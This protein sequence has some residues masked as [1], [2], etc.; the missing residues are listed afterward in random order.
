MPDL[1]SLSRALPGRVLSAEADLRSYSF[2]ASLGRALPGAVVLARSALEVRA[3]VDWC[4]RSGVP[5]VAR[6][7]G[8]NLSGGCVPLRGAVVVSTAAMNRILA[9]SPRDS[10]ALVEPGVVNLRLQRALEPEGLFFPPDPASHRVCTI[11]GNIGENA[12]GP[13]C[14][15]YG[16]TTHHV[17]ALEA[18]LPDGSAARF[19]ASDP[20]P[21]LLSLFVGSEGTLGVATRAS[22]NIQRDPPVRCALLAGFSSIEDAVGA[23]SAVIAAG[24][25]PRTLEAMDRLTVELIEAFVP[26]GYPRTEAVLLLELEDGEGPSSE[27]QAERV[28]ELLRGLGACELRRAEGPLERERLWEGRRSAYAA[29]A[30]RA[31]S[32]LV[33]DGVVPRGRLPEAARRIREIAASE[34]VTAS[35]LF[36]AGDGNIHPNMIFD[37]RDREATARVRRAGRRML[38]ACVE[39][40]GSISG[41][42]GIGTEKRAAMGSMF[43]EPALEV[44]SRIRRAFDPSLLSNP[45]K[46]LP[47][48]GERPPGGL[49]R[50][51][52]ALSAPAEA[53]RAAVRERA[54]EG[55]PFSVFGARSRVP[56]EV[57]SAEKAGAFST[58]GLSSIVRLD[59]ED[60]TVTVEAGIL[61]NDLLGL[62]EA[63][64][65]HAPLPPGKGT[66]GGLMAVKPPPPLRDALLGVRVVLADGSLA[67]FGG[68]T[69]KNVAGY[70][71][72][73][74]L[75]GSWGTLAVIL[76]AT[77]RLSAI[78]V[79]A[80]R[81]PAR[82]VPP[83]MGFWHK[84]LQEALDP[85]GLLN[86]WY[87]RLYG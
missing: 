36:H 12:G 80:G 47:L 61:V 43:D 6:G 58:R 18:V 17:L 60:F 14:L 7:G 28:S 66:L 73:R 19:S 22:L 44:F 64:G 59:P 74:L 79:A 56:E 78:P 37:E 1:R 40:G 72:G 29:C 3:A 75:L 30:R 55:R 71:V 68:R 45:D 70:D 51:S 2:D 48:P 26:A 41:E 21:D 35:L 23:V 5:F 81:D 63:R 57:L 4:A 15:K 46:L 34:G 11:G 67:E 20:G 24:I 33:E 9:V 65:L 39:L 38:E 54:L 83:R 86:P 69:V 84:R 42:H 16:V 27:A 50:K 25:L 82:P 76:E 49:L 8:T 62:L 85:R 10:S 52:A 32:V 77:L 53:L 87:R 31:P 13:R